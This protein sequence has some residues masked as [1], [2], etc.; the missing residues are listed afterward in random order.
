MGTLEIAHGKGGAVSGVFPTVPFRVHGIKQRAGIGGYI[1]GVNIVVQLVFDEVKLAVKAVFQ[2]EIRNGAP[3]L[4]AGEHIAASGTDVVQMVGQIQLI[5]VVTEGAEQIGHLQKGIL[6]GNGHILVRH[7]VEIQEV[8]HN[9]DGF[10][11]LIVV[12]G[13]GDGEA[14]VLHGLEERLVVVVIIV[15]QAFRASIAVKQKVVDVGLVPGEGLG[16]VGLKG[17][18]AVLTAAGGKISDHGQTEADHGQ[19]AE[20]QG[21]QSAGNFHIGPLPDK[22]QQNHQ[23]Q[24]G[25]YGQYGPGFQRIPMGIQGLHDHAE[26]DDDQHGKIR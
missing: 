16:F 2:Q 8:R 20:G 1:V 13:A 26:V 22:Q 15:L 12:A 4:I 18:L 10:Q 19:Y 7:V 21:E 11:R 17:L 23:K 5:A 24:D 6:F 9:G 3:G 14:L 25:K